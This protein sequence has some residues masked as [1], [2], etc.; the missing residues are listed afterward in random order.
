[1]VIPEANS[2]SISIRDIKYARGSSSSTS[3]VTLAMLETIRVD[4]TIV[5][6]EI[7]VRK[8][9]RSDCKEWRPF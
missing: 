1:M 9:M 7:A 2:E 4:T 5:A 8:L 6:I 3:M